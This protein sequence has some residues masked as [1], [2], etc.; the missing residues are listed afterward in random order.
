MPKQQASLIVDIGD[1][2]RVTRR[3]AKLMEGDAELVS[4][5]SALSNSLTAK[6][7]GGTSHRQDGG[8]RGSFRCVC[9][10]FF[11][12]HDEMI[13][14]TRCKNWSHAVC[15]GLDAAR[16]KLARSTFVCV[17]CGGEAQRKRARDAL[18]DM[19]S[20][21]S[22][23][24]KL[25]EVPDRMPANAA[26]L[27]DALTRLTDIA[28]AQ[29]FELMFATPAVLSDSVVEQCL[30]CCASAIQSATFS[31]SYPE[32]CISELRNAPH[33]YL[34]GTMMRC[35]ATKRIVSMVLSN[36][37]DVYGSL[38]ST[39]T[40][41]RSLRSR[42]PDAQLTPMMAQCLDIH[43]VS[44]FVHI[45]LIATH[46]NYR[47]RHLAKMLIAAE[48]I[49]WGL[50]GRKQVYLNMALDKSLVDGRKVVCSVS[51]AS[52]KLY[53][54]FQFK[55]VCQR[56]SSGGEASEEHFTPKEIDSGRVMAN[57]DYVDIV[58]D[59][60]GQLKAQSDVALKKSVK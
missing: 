18:A 10:R 55:P 21:S 20:K 53:D 54:G 52:Q 9:P 7:L 12:P 4:S 13:E 43:D 39:I 29:G 42:N 17:F 26:A 59:V 37:M 3:L 46:P 2:T 50:R 6:S 35:K 44:P 15:N 49:R 58:L 1:K 56:V 38:R 48:L 28:A 8:M 41:I 36:G 30:G 32:Y 23:F 34:Q 60:V 25:T 33:K 45:N 40:Q 22:M 57:L 47:G 11:A 14:C 27:S 51:I 5:S 19:P 24:L 31:E 16:L